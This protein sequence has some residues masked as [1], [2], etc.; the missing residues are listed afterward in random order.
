MDHFTCLHVHKHPRLKILHGW[1]QA[2]PGIT[3]F[4]QNPLAEEPL[5]CQMVFVVLEIA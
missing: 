1:G 2:K 3:R 4:V 5:D